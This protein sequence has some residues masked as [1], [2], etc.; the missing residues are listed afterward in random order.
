MSEEYG[1]IQAFNASRQYQNKFEYFF[2]GVILASLSLSVQ[3]KIPEEA[4]SLYL[5]IASWILFLISFLSGLFRFERINM[6]FRIE[7][8]KL[9][10]Y[11]KRNNFTEAKEGQLT[12]LKD[13]KSEWK[14]EE[15]IEQ[16]S[17]FEG[18]LE[19]ADRFISYYN[20]QSSIA[21]QIQKWGFLFGLV[22]FALYKISN[23][24]HLTVCTE[25]LIL[26]TVSVGLILV[27]LLYKKTLPFSEN[28]TNEISK[29]D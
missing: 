19:S 20:K 22:S 27:V 10:F 2:M 25:F 26:F 3:I 24:F 15:I 5:L 7:A 8:E 4:T 1:Y 13:S 29:T 17:K 9:S 16:I 23:I 14:P 18:L 11:K 12:L 21:Y 28:E 6:F